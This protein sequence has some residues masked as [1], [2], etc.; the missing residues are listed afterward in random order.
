VLWGRNVYDSIRKFLQF[1][2]TVNLVAL[3]I[4]FVSAITSGQSVLTP[5]Q[6][7]WVNL[8]MDTMGALALATE[9]PSNELLNRKPYGRNDNLITPMMWCFIV[10][11]SIFQV[12]AL[13]L[14]MFF[15]DIYFGVEKYS[16]VHTTIIFN[17]FVFCQIVNEI[18]STRI[19][20]ELDV[21]SHIPK[22]KIFLFILTSTIL[23]QYLIVEYGGSFTDTTPLTA[24]QWIYC[25]SIA[26]LGFPIGFFLRLLV[27]P[28]AKRF[29]AK[30][31]AQR[32]KNE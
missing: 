6:L 13:F 29:L 20:G 24:Q 12:I 18:N 3:T 25:L 8:I 5:V 26:S 4:A 23:V 11:Q 16:L 15:G 2:L 28:L 10:G 19:Y 17:T 22:N 1:Q 31:S 30:N 27:R 9:T 14:L 32:L 21:F 7:L